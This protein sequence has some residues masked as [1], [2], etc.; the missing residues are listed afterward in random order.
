M[1]M[2]YAVCGLGMRLV[3]FS[4]LPVLIT[5][6]VLYSVSHYYQRWRWPGDKVSGCCITVLVP[7]HTAMASEVGQSLVI[8]PHKGKWLVAV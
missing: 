8:I 6:S 2:K 7:V 4:G 1:H 5:Y 3:S